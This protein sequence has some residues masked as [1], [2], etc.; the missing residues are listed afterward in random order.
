MATVSKHSE[1]AAPVEEV[2]AWHERPGAIQRLLPPWEPVRV[3]QS[4]PSLE[5]GNRA[6]LRTSVP[7]PLVSRWVAEHTGYDPPREF[8]DVQVSGPFAD[9]EHRHGFEETA[10]DRTLISDEISYRLPLDTR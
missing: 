3:E 8:R 2:F 4:A 5:P 7:G 1:V 10:P 6:V 9:F